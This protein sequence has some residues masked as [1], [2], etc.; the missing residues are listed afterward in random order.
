VKTYAPDPGVLFQVWLNDQHSSTQ[1]RHVN[2]HATPGRHRQAGPSPQPSKVFAKL[3]NINNAYESKQLQGF[4]E[5]SGTAVREDV[6]F[7]LA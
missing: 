5:W 1:A 7:A 4:P 2:E 3:H 6:N